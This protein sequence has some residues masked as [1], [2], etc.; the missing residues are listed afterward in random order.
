MT[1]K[2]IQFVPL[3]QV[4]TPI[5]HVCGLQVYNILSFLQVSDEED[6][7]EEDVWGDRGGQQQE[8]KTQ[9]AEVDQGFRLLGIK[10]EAEEINKKFLKVQTKSKHNFYM[11]NRKL[12]LE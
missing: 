4:N 11:C 5:A 10:A 1:Y 3:C 7:D 8:S 12:T 9:A 2:I 6:G